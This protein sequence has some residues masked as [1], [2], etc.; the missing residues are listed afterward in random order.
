MRDSAS[1]SFGRLLDGI[2]SMGCAAATKAVDDKDVRRRVGLGEA[3]GPS[4]TLRQLRNGSRAAVTTTLIRCPLYPRKPPTC[5]NAQV[6]SFGHRLV[7]CKTWDHRT[8]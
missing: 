6:V 7:R 3:S 8:N 1:W 5:G 2:L 4:V